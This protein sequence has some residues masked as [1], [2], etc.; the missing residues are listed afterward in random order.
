MVIDFE[1]EPRRPLEERRAKSAPLRD[2]AGML[3]SLDYAAWSAWQRRTDIA[4][5][6]EAAAAR[7]EAWREH[8]TRTFRDAYA[9][10]MAG[11]EAHP[12]EAFADALLDLFVVQKAVY[13]VGY[14]LA[15][16]PAWVTIPL[17]GLLALADE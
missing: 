15:S 10:T 8:A 3:R 9:E 11:S 1:G 4:Q 13:E 17:R 2:V 6:T 5:D 12:S 7:V 14:E 16:R